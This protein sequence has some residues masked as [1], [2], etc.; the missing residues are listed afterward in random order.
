MHIYVLYILLNPAL[1]DPLF[2]KFCLKQMHIFHCFNLFWI[3]PITD[4]NYRS[5]EIRELTVH[6]WV[7]T[8][9]NL[10]KKISILKIEIIEGK[11]KKYSFIDIGP[12][13]SGLA[14]P[15]LCIWQKIY[16]EKWSVSPYFLHHYE[17]NNEAGIVF[18]IKLSLKTLSA[19]IF[20]VFWLKMQFELCD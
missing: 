9:K 15:L 20:I 18:F 19:Y 6:I 17:D 11:V 16:E 8:F 10:R 3:L 12:W 1:T 4:K 2:T 14:L 5:P 13:E 7:K